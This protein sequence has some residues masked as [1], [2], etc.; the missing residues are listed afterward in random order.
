MS[1][2]T[3]TGAYYQGNTL[4]RRSLN[5]GRLQ[6]LAHA[7]ITIILKARNRSETLGFSLKR[8]IL[9]ADKEK[10]GLKTYQPVSRHFAI[11]VES[12]RTPYETMKPETQPCRELQG[13]PDSCL[14]KTWQG[15]PCSPTKPASNSTTC[16]I[17]FPL[18]TS[19]P[20]WFMDVIETFWR[21]SIETYWNNRSEEL[22][23]LL[24]WG[25]L[26]F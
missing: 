18:I 10:E 22:M 14:I 7:I 26:R 23:S 20:V 15:T 24:V 5:T 4:T 3:N 12:R 1:Q 11:H 25:I 6:S 17:L 16:F 8:E 2:K 9:V 13:L 21:I 19:L